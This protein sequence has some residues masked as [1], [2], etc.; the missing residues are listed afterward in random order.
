MQSKLNPLTISQD[1]WQNWHWKSDSRYYKV[2]LHKDLFGNWVLS[3][4]WGGLN[5]H[6]NG[7][8]SEVINIKD[9]DNLIENINNIRKTR[10]YK[11][12]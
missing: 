12:I 4:E 5:N 1:I 9:L 8:K 3:K 10:C 11:L 7:G 2:L 6:I